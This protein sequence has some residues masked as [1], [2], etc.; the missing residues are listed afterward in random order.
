MANAKM[1]RYATDDKC[2]HKGGP[3]SAGQL[4]GSAVICPWHGACFDVTD[5][6]VLLGPAKK[7]VECFRVMIAGEIGHVER[8]ELPRALG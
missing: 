5:D 7:P 2:T 6:Q 3:L 8:N 4:N 1:Q